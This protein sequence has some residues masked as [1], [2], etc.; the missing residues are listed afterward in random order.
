[1][2]KRYMSITELIHITGLSRDHL[3][4][5]SRIKNAP[6]IRTLGRGKIL[7]DMEQF[8]KFLKETSK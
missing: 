2:K 5:L 4:R 3:K 8:D 6:T 7:F 1:M